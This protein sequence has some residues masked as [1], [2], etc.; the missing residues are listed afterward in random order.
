MRT[1]R[2]LFTRVLLGT[3]LVAP[4]ASAETLTGRVWKVDQIQSERREVTCGASAP[5]APSVLN[6]SRVEPYANDGS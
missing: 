1:M 3:T 5:I 6:S 2:A 4:I